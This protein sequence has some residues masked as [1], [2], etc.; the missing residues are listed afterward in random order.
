[1]PILLYYLISFVQKIIPFFVLHILEI[2]N[3]YQTNLYLVLV[4][5]INL[6]IDLF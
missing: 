2:V 5:I 3:S 1:M 6:F 4:L